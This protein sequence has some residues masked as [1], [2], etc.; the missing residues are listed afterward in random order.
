MVQKREASLY[1][2]QPYQT[3]PLVVL[4]DNIRT[5][6]PT[7]QWILDHH[8]VKK[9]GPRL[10]LLDDDLRFDTRRKDKPDLF[11]KATD[12]DMVRMFTQLENLL[13]KFAHA[14]ILGREGGNRVMEPYRFATRMMRVLAYHVPTVRKVKARFD[15]VPCKQDFDMTLQMLRAGYTNAVICAY[16]QGQGRGSGAVGGCS[17]YRTM[18]MMEK[19]CY[20]LAKLHPGL[21]KVVERETVSAWGGGQ[22]DIPVVRKEV[23]MAWKKAY[24]Q[25]VEKFGVGR[26][27]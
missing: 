17:A 9:F 23:E 7:R 8:D 12:K 16:V 20:K 18:E 11:L 27:V 15:R 19:T 5:L 22:H 6:S 21:V 13:S 10:C 2:R 26:L 4:P 14:G 3:Y 1:V 24:D 25:G